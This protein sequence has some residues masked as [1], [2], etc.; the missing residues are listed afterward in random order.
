MVV[1]EERKGRDLKDRR[2]IRTTTTFTEIFDDLAL[3][4]LMFCPRIHMWWVLLWVY[5]ITCT[6]NGGRPQV[7]P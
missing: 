2:Q 6:A 5:E 4:P 7:R 3:A 1:E